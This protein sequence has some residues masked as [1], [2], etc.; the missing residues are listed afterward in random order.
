MEE[1]VIPVSPHERSAVCCWGGH[2]SDYCEHVSD[3][4]KGL[5]GEL[6]WLQPRQHNRCA[7]RRIGTFVHNASETLVMHLGLGYHIL[8]SNEREHAKHTISHVEHGAVW[9]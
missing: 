8:T 4:H 5:A 2:A 3:K 9:E 6:P 1:I 7:I